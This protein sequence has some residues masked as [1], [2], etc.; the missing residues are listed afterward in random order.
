MAEDNQTCNKYIF[1]DCTNHFQKLFSNLKK[2]FFK[3]LIVSKVDSLIFSKEL[4][5]P[6]KKIKVNPNYSKPYCKFIIKSIKESRS[7][8]K[9]YVYEDNL[10]LFKAD[11]FQINNRDP[12]F[13]RFKHIRSTSKTNK[14][15]HKIG[16]LSN[17]Y[18]LN[19]LSNLFAL[20][21]FL[22]S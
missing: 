12:F 21:N 22:S 10:L 13:V 5:F 20:N 2:R 9:I 18:C 16:I 11:I 7:F 1:K 14:G 17:I 19:N 15:F 8:I 4:A 3:D 6:S